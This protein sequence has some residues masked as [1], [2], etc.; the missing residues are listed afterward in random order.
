V[1]QLRL[2][3]TFDGHEQPGGIWTSYPLPAF[4]GDYQFQF[5]LDGPSPSIWFPQLLWG[6]GVPVTFCCVQELVILNGQTSSQVSMNT[7]GS[8]AGT[9][10]GF[11]SC[12]DFSA[13][14]VT[15]RNLGQ[16]P[17][18]GMTLTLTLSGAG[19]L[20]TPCE[21][22]TT[23]TDEGET[24][25]TIDNA[26]IDAVAARAGMPW[27]ARAFLPL[28]GAT[29]TPSD[30]CGAGPPVMPAIDHTIFGWQFTY[31][32][33]TFDAVGWGF[34]CKCVDGT[35][36]PT[37]P[38]PI[39]QPQPPEWEPP[40][41]FTCDPA[42]LCASIVEIQK[43]LAALQVVV[44]KNFEL[45]TLM[46]RYSLPFAVIPGA[47]HSGLTGSGSFAMSRLVGLRVEVT[48]GPPSLVLPG[49]PRY[50]WDV[51][52]M[53][54]TDQGAMLQEKRITRDRMDWLPAGCPLAT[55]FGFEANPAVTLRVTELQA[56]P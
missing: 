29:V 34:F 11:W 31:L 48:S 46:Q 45:A 14:F 26:L 40:H 35:P 3:Y 6:K 23:T 52:W 16:I 18:A 2:T 19:V 9:D 15:A 20:G 54:V 10:K 44:A 17:P 13:I 53:S 27:I 50:L 1:G 30:L 5:S 36:P 28:V 38:P 55:V 47:V 41:T 8:P 12:T 24:L 51:G 33:R 25:R 22:G 37:P 4:T 43:N 32:L 39:T 21:Y 7:V 49:N 56:E 42:D